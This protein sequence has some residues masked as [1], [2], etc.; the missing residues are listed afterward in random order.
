MK[1]K[2]I[3]IFPA[4]ICGMTFMPRGKKRAKMENLNMF[5]NF[6]RLFCRNFDAFLNLFECLI[7]PRRKILRYSSI[8]FEFLAEI[9]RY[10]IL[11]NKNK[12]TIRFNF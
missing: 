7:R 1:N 12:I 8:L 3:V 5:S 2:E 4:N 6:I 11:V 9:F 10:E